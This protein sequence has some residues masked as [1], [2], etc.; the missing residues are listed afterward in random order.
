MLLNQ[1]LTSTTRNMKFIGHANLLHMLSTKIK[2]AAQSLTAIHGLGGLGYVN[3][4]YSS[5]GSYIR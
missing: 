5:Y 4:S 1:L 3:P 2:W